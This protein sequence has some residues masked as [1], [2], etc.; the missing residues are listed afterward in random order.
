MLLLLL[1]NC[2]RICCTFCHKII[3][4]LAAMDTKETTSGTMHTCIFAMS[5]TS[6]YIF[7]WSWAHSHKHSQC[8][9]YTTSLFPSV[10]SLTFL[11]IF[12]IYTSSRPFLFFSPFL[13]CSVGICQHIQIINNNGL[14][15]I[16]IHINCKGT[17]ATYIGT[18]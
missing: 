8:K 14:K 1:L 15:K 12:Y 5:L 7:T 3:T 11:Y 9:K 17:L 18:V 4:M 16:Y 2:L 10:Q 6:P 13:S